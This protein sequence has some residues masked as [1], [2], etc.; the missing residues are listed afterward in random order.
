MNGEFVDT[1][2]LVYAHDRSAGRKFDIARALIQHLLDER[3]GLLSVQVLMEFYVTVTQKLPNPLSAELAKEILVDL[4]TWRLFS[5]NPSDVIDAVQLSQK[6]RISLWDAM[7]IHAADKL[8]AALLWSEDLSEGQ[9]F[10]GVTVR[11][12]FTEYRE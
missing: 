6:H 8:G 1:N 12:P 4:K 3:K 2:I 9:S 10:G 7:I 5:P 11:N